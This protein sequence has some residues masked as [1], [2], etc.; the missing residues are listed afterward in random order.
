MSVPSVATDWRSLAPENARRVPAG[1]HTGLSP[2]VTTVCVVPSS[3]T[4]ARVA[5]AWSALYASFV[6]SG[7]H[8]RSCTSVNG[9]AGGV[10]SNA[11][12]PAPLVCAT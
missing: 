1:D 2:S 3:T 4:I 6:P 12:T 10:V 8:A 9:V 7:D 11:V 5:S